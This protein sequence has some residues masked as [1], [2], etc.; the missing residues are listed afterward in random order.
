MTKHYWR[1]PRDYID[2]EKIEAKKKILGY[3]KELM[4]RGD[5]QGYIELLRKLNPKIS[6]EEIEERLTQ[7][8]EQRSVHPSDAWNLP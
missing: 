1:P 6:N 4:E 7:F 5:E 2:Q 3:I 8:R